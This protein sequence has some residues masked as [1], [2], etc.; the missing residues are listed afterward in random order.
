MADGDDDALETLGDME[1]FLKEEAELMDA[2]LT[3]CFAWSIGANIH[4]SSREKFDDFCKTRFKPLVAAKYAL[5]MQQDVYHVYVDLA[6]KSIK[7]W[8]FITFVIEAS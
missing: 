1:D 4:D 2:L 8:D 5:L 7:L 6:A 3:W